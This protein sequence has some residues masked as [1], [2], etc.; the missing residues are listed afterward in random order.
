MKILSILWKPCSLHHKSYLPMRLQ[1]VGIVH[2]SLCSHTH[3]FVPLDYTYKTQVQ[4]KIIKN[5][6]ITAA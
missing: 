1:Q 4:R 6:E 3:F 2:V 5:F